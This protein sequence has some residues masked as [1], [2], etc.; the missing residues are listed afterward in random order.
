MRRRQ[1]ES[2]FALLFVFLMASTIA[3][4][5]YVQLPRTAFEAQRAKEEMLQERGEQYIRAIQLYVA[6][7][8]SY[9]PSL[10]ALEKTNNVRFLRK[11]YKDPMTGKDEW[12]AIH[13]NAAGQLTDSII[14]KKGEEKKE[15]QNTFISEL[16]GLGA[17][18]QAG[19]T[20]QNVALRRRPSDQAP[21]P[22]QGGNVPIDPQ[23]LGNG[24]QLGS[25][26]GTPIP[27]PQAPGQMQ[28]GQMPQAQQ[29]QAQQGQ[30]QTPQMID[31]RTGQAIPQNP[32]GQ[33]NARGGEAGLAG[34]AGQ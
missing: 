20:A 5:M 21:M 2:G 11:R 7:W 33:P 17:A 8:R 30:A 1:Q 32:Y 31:P 6:K 26:V 15:Y 4:M 12:R 3:I 25:P 10:D 34:T 14:K 19:E 28:P 27:D 22:G 29:A 13:V 23:S 18:G 9:P 24:A 16:P